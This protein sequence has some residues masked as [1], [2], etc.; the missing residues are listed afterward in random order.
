MKKAKV[1]IVMPAYNEEAN[2]PSVAGEWYAVVARLM[3]EGFDAILVIANDGSTDAT[4]SVLHGL[5][6]SRPGLLVLDKANSGHGATLHYLYEYALA[7]GADYV[8][9]TD[10][11]GQTLATEFALLW[12]CRDE[13][14][15]QTGLRN[16][17]GDGMSRR[18]VAK[19]LKAVVRL[20]FGIS[21]PDANTPFR[22]FKAG[23]LRRIMDIIPAD[24]FLTNAA[25]SAI[26]VKLGLRTRWVPITF[27]PRRGGTNT[28]NLSGIFKI[29]LSAIRDFRKI[30]RALQ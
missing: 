1:F 2:L 8:F 6:E 9:Q 18:F 17:R 22:L 14:D 15:M 10:S 16:K 24:F 19:V 21:V 11:D 13:Y 7:E 29:G 30:N 4:S 27:L 28:I 25:A 23:A 20:T 12:A 26:A 3:D 5:A